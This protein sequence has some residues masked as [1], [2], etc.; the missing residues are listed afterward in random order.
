MMRDVYKVT[1]ELARE[2]GKGYDVDPFETYLVNEI[3]KVDDE[4]SQIE[5]YHFKYKALQ[6]KKK[7][8]NQVREAY[9]NLNK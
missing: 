1:E 5:T 9:R 6:E 2:L 7:L 3:D 8:L 4:M